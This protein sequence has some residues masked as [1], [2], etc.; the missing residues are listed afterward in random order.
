MDILTTEELAAHNHSGST[1]SAGSH[2][3]QQYANL[4][5]TPQ[6]ANTGI[7]INSSQYPAATGWRDGWGESYSTTG[8][9]TSPTVGRTSNTGNHTHTVSIGNSG[10]NTAHNNMQPYLVIYRYRRTA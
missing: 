2:Y 1:G 9:G 5:A 6:N 4:S 7:N 8:T 3:H 10:N